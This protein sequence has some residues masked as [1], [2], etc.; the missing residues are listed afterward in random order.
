MAIPNFQAVMLPL[1]RFTE[2]Q[3]EHSLRQAIEHLA[4]HFELTPEERR[5]LLPS[6]RQATFDNRVDWARTYLTKAGLL[7]ATRRAHFRITARGL[8]VLKQNPPE[9]NVALLRQFPKFV[10]FQTRGR[11]AAA[12]AG[13][14]EPATP[15]TPEEEIE[16]AYQELTAPLARNCWKPSRA[17]PQPFSN[18]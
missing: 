11:S 8:D 1:L 17:S 2:D 13:E 18:G 10:E 15:Q 4:S 12:V 7:E 14:T 9:I 6:G 3:Q 16:A 5:E